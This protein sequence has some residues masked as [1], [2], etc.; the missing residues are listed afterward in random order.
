MRCD[1]QRKNIQI[2]ELGKLKQTIR[3][4]HRKPE[5]NTTNRTKHAESTC[6]EASINTEVEAKMA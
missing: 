2:M 1:S 5:N 3:I 6:N 4:N